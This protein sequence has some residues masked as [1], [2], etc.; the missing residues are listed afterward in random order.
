MPVEMLMHPVGITNMQYARDVFGNYMITALWL[1][2]ELNEQE[3]II[4]DKYINKMYKKFHK[5]IEFHKEEQGF[6]ATS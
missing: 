4:V 6:Y 1:R 5:P 2:D 3:L